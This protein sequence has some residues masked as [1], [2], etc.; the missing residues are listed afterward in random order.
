MLDIVTTVTYFA[1]LLGFGVIIANICRK[2]GVPDAFFLL[3]LGLLMGPTVFNNPAISNM[4]TFVLVDVTAMGSVPDFLRVLALIMIVFTG[5]FNLSFSAFKKFSN[6]S[7]NLAIIGVIFNT[8]I[9]GVVA[10]LIFGIDWVYSFLLAAVI[11]GTGT[12]VL[13]A[14][15][16]ILSKS[17]KAIAILKIESIFNAPLTVLLPIIFL[18]LVV[19]QPGALFEPMRYATQ[20]WMMVASGV[21]TGIIIGL[22]V[23]KV[24]KGMLRQ[25]T[26]LLLLAVALITYTLAEIIGGSGM[27]AVAVCGILAGNLVFR[28]KKEV[29]AFEDQLSEML[30]ISV[31]TLLGAQ[32]MFTLTMTQTL[33]V[34]VF[35]VAVFLFRPIFVYP[36]LGKDIRKDLSRKE[37]MLVSFVAPRGLAAAAMA[38]IV[39]TVIIGIGY[40][41]VANVILNIIFLIVLLS[42]LFSSIV[43][44]MMREKLPAELAGEKVELTEYAEVKPPKK[45]NGEV[46][47]AGK[48][49][50]KKTKIPL[51]EEKKKKKGLL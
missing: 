15:E 40:P 14:F 13:L 48:A 1:F 44:I 28:E 32:I 4:F 38:P 23:S 10:H 31:F 47:K 33:M 26:P 35:F 11:G 49:A 21:G 18:D 2:Y 16:N 45:I 8:I 27:L 29:R 17:R 43:A 25:Y 20:F 37:M 7:V 19:L 36:T 3:M 34:L 51:K 39:A 41:V 50:V 6:V 30:R 12:G 46:V 42:V 22:A 9:L 5:A 24:M